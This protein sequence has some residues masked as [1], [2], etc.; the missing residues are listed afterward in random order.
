MGRPGRTDLSRAFEEGYDCFV[1][2]RA[3]PFFFSNTCT[4]TRTHGRNAWISTPRHIE[5]KKEHVGALL[6]EILA[7]WIAAARRVSWCGRSRSD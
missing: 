4:R 7:E 5:K 6:L 2:R 3:F 1:L